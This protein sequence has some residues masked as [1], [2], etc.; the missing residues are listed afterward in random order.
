MPVDSGAAWRYRIYDVDYITHIFDVL[1]FLNGTDTI[2]GSNTYH[3]LLSRT[4]NLVVPNDSFP[5]VV[6]VEATYPDTYYGAIRENSKKVYSLNDI[7]GG[8]TLIFNFN[9][10]IGDSIPAYNGLDRVT[11]IDS[12]LLSGVYHKRYLTNDATYSVIEGV[13][14][15]RGL[16]PDL[17]DGGSDIAF[18]CFTDSSIT[19]S[20]DTSIPCTYIYPLGYTSAVKNANVINQ[21]I[22]IY[23]IPASDILHIFS[24]NNLCNAQVV[25][26]NMLGQIVW[27]GMFQN[28]LDIP[29]STWPSGIYY[30]RLNYNN[31]GCITNEFSIK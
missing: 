20:P 25:I 7:G 6:D 26:I 22:E 28:K 1:I 15:N 30:F 11:G 18:Y 10:S 14:S 31:I 13:G 12:I 9:A 8:E 3:K 29:V 17:N 19:Y 5:P 23:P 24:V 16:F 4:A 21:E 27:Q 2:V